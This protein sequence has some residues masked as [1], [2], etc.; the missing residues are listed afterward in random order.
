MVHLGVTLAL[1]VL[2]RAVRRD[3]RR[4]HHRALPHQQASLGHV[5]IDFGADRRAELVCLEQTAKLQQ[6]RCIRHVLPGPID[7]DKLA[8]GLAVVQRVLECFVGQRV[9]L[10][11]LS[12]PSP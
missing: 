12:I 6:R 11:L 8:H 7:A 2:R 4:V 5:R 1:S 3:D 9:P 10:L